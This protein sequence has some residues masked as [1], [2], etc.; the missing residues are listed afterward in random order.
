MGQVTSISSLSQ[1]SDKV[2]AGWGGVMF[3]DAVVF[4][5]FAVSYSIR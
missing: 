3:D 1:T 2:M 4:A 5:R